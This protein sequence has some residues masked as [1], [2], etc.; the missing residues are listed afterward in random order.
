MSNSYTKAAF[1]IAVTAAEADLLRRVIGA[2][3]LIC[4]ASVGLEA[5]EAHYL[6]MGDDFATLFPR[7]EL[8]P[9]DGLLDL[10]PDE[11]YPVLDC[12]IDFGD[13]SETGQIVVFF[14]GEQFGVEVAAQLIQR[15]AP[16]V[17]PFG[18]EFAFDADKLRAGELG[19]G[20]VAITT[21]AIEYGHTTLMLARAVARALD[22]GADG[23]VL[24]ARDPEHG[25]GFWNKD[26]GFGRLMNATV[27]SE[28]EAAKFDMSI[29][30]DQPEWLAM[31]AP[32]RF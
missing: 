8:S 15:C 4:D 24:A 23:F 14:S 2:I 1:G 7:T 18:F 29:A 19:G 32:L 27:F 12:D 22:E 28:S 9:F 3:E 31:P 10:F 16:S 26:H 21:S 13:P 30:A 17:L 11:N 20:Y 5:L 25:L 6:G